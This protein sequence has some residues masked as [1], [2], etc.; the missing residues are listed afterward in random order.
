MILLRCILLLCVT[1]PQFQGIG[2]HLFWT[3]TSKYVNQDK[4]FLIW[5]CKLF[6]WWNSERQTL[7]VIIYAVFIESLNLVFSKST[8]FSNHCCY[9]YW[10]QKSINFLYRRYPR[11]SSCLPGLGCSH[12]SSM[13]FFWKCGSFGINTKNI[14]KYWA[15]GIVPIRNS[16][17]KYRTLVGIMPS[18]STVHWRQQSRGLLV[19]TLR[20]LL[21]IIHY[22]F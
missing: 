15:S 20:V 14:L 13:K 16:P 12:L 19:T 22:G 7:L 8:T 3:K 4:T 11:A 21:L 6:K 1:L 2:A 5:F 18:P 9:P 17:K 10:Q